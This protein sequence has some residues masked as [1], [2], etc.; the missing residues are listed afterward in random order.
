M[1]KARR[2]QS[3]KPKVNVED[4]INDETTNPFSDPFKPPKLRRPKSKLEQSGINGAEFSRFVWNMVN[5]EERTTRPEPQVLL[6]FHIQLHAD[7]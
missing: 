4:K 2:T 3:S 6:M 1:P 7:F 5:E